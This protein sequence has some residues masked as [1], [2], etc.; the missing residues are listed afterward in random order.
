MRP[1]FAIALLVGFSGVAAAQEKPVPKDSLR[2]SIPGCSKGVVFT[3]VDSPEHESR[4][5]VAPGRRFR[6]AG[7][8]KL[9]DE[10]KAWEGAVIEVTG[11]IKRGQIDESGVSLG[12]GVS[13]GPGP[14][15]LGGVGRSANFNQ[16]VL[17]VEGWRALTGDCPAR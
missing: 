16:I 12:G 11:L 13:I 15:P 8:K 2:I 9:L 1:L 10:I 3:V 7:P 6:L 4:S 17:D 14:S 5:S